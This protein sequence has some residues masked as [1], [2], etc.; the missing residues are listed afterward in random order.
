VLARSDT[1][2]LRS[3]VIQ[4]GGDQFD[5]VTALDERRREQQRR[6]E[7]A[8]EDVF[9]SD[10]HSAARQLVQAGLFDRRSLRAAALQAAS[11]ATRQGEMLERAATAA[12]NVWPLQSRTE[13]IGVLLVPDRR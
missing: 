4:S 11:A 6:R 10:R 8:I 7:R 5:R 3:L 1:A 2:I 9:A 13:L 12:A